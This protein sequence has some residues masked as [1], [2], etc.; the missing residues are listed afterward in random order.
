ML[1]VNPVSTN[2]MTHSSMSRLRSWTSAP[3]IG[4]PTLLVHG[5][6][7]SI[8]PIAHGER[9]HAAFTGGGAE[10]VAVAGAGHNDLLRRPEVWRELRRFLGSR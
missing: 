4:V 6:V 5:S 9:L 1:A 8:I 2:V 3:E 7:D 10:M